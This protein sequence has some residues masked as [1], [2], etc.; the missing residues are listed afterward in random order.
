MPTW[1]KSRNDPPHLIK[2]NLQT[3]LSRNFFLLL[4][5]EITDLL[6]EKDVDIDFEKC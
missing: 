5:E 1:E 3:F 4:F 2:F 6:E